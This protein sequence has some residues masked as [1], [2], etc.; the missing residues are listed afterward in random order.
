M[1]DQRIR[2]IRD[3]GD[4]TEW[5]ADAIN[6]GWV[7][8]DKHTDEEL[9]ESAELLSIENIPTLEELKNEGI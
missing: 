5:M 3:N 4:E 7:G 2:S 9:I 6:F 8:Y 1:V